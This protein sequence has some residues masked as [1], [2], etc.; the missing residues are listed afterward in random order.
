[1]TD[2]EANWP[3]KGDRLFM[4]DLPDWQH[5][6]HTDRNW[7]SDDINQWYAYAFGYREAG[8]RVLESAIGKGPRGVLDVLVYPVVFVYRHHFELMLKTIV[9]IGRRYDD[10]EQEDLGYHGLTSLWQKAREVIEKHWPKSAKEPVDATEQLIRELDDLDPRSFAFR[11][12][13]K[14]DGNRALPG[15][16]K[17]NLRHFGKICERMSNFLECCLQGLWNELDEKQEFLAEM[18]QMYG[19]EW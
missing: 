17:A 19:G 12:S 3:K 10:E 4:A 2:L 9:R 11:Y 13:E 1:M 16:V 5:T 18:G 15:P 7:F 8:K 14:K 6:A